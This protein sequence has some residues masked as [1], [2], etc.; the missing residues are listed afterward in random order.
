MADPSFGRRSAA[1][2]QYVMQ[3]QLRSELTTLLQSQVNIRNPSY[4]D[5]YGGLSP[6]TFVVRICGA[7]RQHPETTRSRTRRRRAQRSA[8]RSSCGRT[9]RCMSTA[10]SRMS[11]DD[12]A[13]QHQHAGSGDGPAADRRWG[14]VTELGSRGFHDYRAMY[15]RRRQ[16]FSRPAS[17]HALVHVS[18]GTELGL[19]GRRHG[20]R[21]RLLQSVPRLRAGQ[22]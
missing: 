21:H 3:N 15:V 13:G 4:P 1:Y 2:Y 16:A 7:E 11:T 17:V 12:P 14:N 20:R 22:R 19:D 6:Q 5:P 18:E 9:W 8:S 10:S